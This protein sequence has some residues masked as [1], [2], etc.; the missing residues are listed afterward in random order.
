MLDNSTATL[1]GAW[2]KES[3]LPGFFGSN[4]LSDGNAGKGTK[5]AR[6][7]ATFTFDGYYQVFA[8][9]TSGANRASSVPIDVVNASN[10]RTVLVN[11]QINGGQWFSLGVYFFKQSGGSVLIRNTGT[12]GFVVAD[13]VKFVAVPEPATLIK[14]NTDAGVTFTGAWTT[15][16]TPAGY[17]GTNYRSDGNPAVK[18]THSV[19]YSAG[20]LGSA[21]VYEVFAWWTAGANRASNARYDILTSSGT[22]TVLANQKTR[23][24]QWVSL[25]YFDLNKVGAA[26]TLRNNNANGLVIAD[27]VRFVRVE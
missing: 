14:D 10:T 27:A 8:R 26:V 17:D 19:T 3:S 7:A 11:Q 24:G 6:F 1:V 15:S 21:G 20:N 13:A 5:S 23:G 16:T 18:G 9:W 4:Y 2:T 22:K 12:N 25:G